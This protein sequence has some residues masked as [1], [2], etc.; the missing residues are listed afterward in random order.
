MKGR[1]TKCMKTIAAYRRIVRTT[2]GLRASKRRKTPPVFL[3][4]DLGLFRK[5]ER[6]PWQ[7]YV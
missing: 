4:D 2:L 6:R 7:D 1:L 3:H 5:L